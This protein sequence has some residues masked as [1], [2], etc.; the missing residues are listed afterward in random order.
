MELTR[1]SELTGVVHTQEIPITVSEYEDW[2]K[3]GIHIQNYFP[4]LSVSD[5]EFMLTGSTDEEWDKAFGDE[6]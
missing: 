6:E 4:E 2:K 5:R 3:S 1:K